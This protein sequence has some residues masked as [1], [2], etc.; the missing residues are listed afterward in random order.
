MKLTP[1]A[2]REFQGRIYASYKKKGR[3]LP[4]RRTKDPYRILI[5]EVMLQQTQVSRVVEKYHEFLKEFPD[6]FSLSKA[7]LRN[8]MRAWQGL[9]YN[10]RALSLKKAAGII[11]DRYQ[12]KLPSNTEAL[13][14]LPGIGAATAA[15]ICAFAFNQPTVFIETNI[16]SVFIHHFFRKRRSV[17]DNQILQLVKQTLDA[18][19]P[20]QWY[21]ALMDYGVSLKQKHPNPN[22]KSIHYKKQSSFQG[23]NR[24]AR[25][26]IL[27]ALVKKP[28]IKK[29][30]IFT[31]IQRSKKTLQNIIHQLSREGL[32]REKGRFISLR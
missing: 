5:S 32:V 20:R 4:W 7:P 8:V 30:I 11:V 2:T 25:G 16:R 28:Q 26:L 15:E 3:D 29:S 22:R 24:Q 6:I 9:G 21:Y 14:E 10:R 1:R 23:S 13:M 31:E 18:K 27:K 19:N 12:G 17:H